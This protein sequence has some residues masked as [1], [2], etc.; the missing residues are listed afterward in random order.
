MTAQQ[1]SDGID[2]ELDKVAT[3]ALPNLLPSEKEY[4]LN[5]AQDMFIK[6]RYG[7]NN[8]VRTSVE[9]T[10]KRTDDLK[11]LIQNATLFPIPSGPF[12]PGSTYSEPN[13]IFFKLPDGI[14][15]ID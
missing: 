3:L 4:F 10:Q 5:K 15:V 7:G 14:T 8:S 1:F 12:G 13:G 11:A 9:E 6:Q 2:L